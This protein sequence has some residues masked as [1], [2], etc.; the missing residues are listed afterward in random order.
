MLVFTKD[1]WSLRGYDIGVFG[2]PIWGV[3][4]LRGTLLGSLL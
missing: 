2:A 4:D 1:V 3:Y